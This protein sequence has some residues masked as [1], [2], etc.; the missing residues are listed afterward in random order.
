M[1][2]YK[3]AY[4]KDEQRAIKL[5]FTSEQG[6]LALKALK[7]VANGAVVDR[8]N[9]NPNNAVYRVAQLDLINF[10]ERQVEDFIK[11]TEKDQNLEDIINGK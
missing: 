2:D 11:E 1:A 7:A 8:N 10:I 6:K 4:Y 9:I 5:L 3:K